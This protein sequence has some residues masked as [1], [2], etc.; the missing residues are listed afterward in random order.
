MFIITIKG[1][2]RFVPFTAVVGQLPRL[3][4]CPRIHRAAF[5]MTERLAITID[6]DPALL[7]ALEAPLLA[8]GAWPSEL[9]EQHHLGEVRCF[10]CDV[11]L[12]G[13]QSEHQAYRVYG[14]ERQDLRELAWLQAN[15]IPRI[16][17]PA[18]PEDIRF[19]LGELGVVI[20]VIGE[21]EQ[22][23]TVLPP[24]ALRH[25]RAAI[26]PTA[27]HPARHRRIERVLLRPGSDP[28]TVETG[29]YGRF[30]ITAGIET[31]RRIPPDD[32]ARRCAPPE[33]EWIDFEPIPLEPGEGG[34][35]SGKL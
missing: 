27:E 26:Y 1:T 18:A 6:R 23:P 16:T 12:T 5:A 34:G 29:S 31:V 32:L 13:F 15:V 25:L 2:S 9:L 17:D 21:H 20:E 19:L 33:R 11:L 4:T 14:L 10:E 28:V 30:V 22:P 8:R 3:A 7:A 24:D 35:Q